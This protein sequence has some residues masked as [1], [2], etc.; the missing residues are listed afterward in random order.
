MPYYEFENIEQPGVYTDL[1]YHHYDAPKI[2]ETVIIERIIWK[3]IASKLTASIDTKFDPN[4]KKDFIKVT[5]KQGTFGEMFDRS[6]E[7]SELRKAQNGVDE[8]KQAYDAKSQ[9][10]GAES[11]AERK[12][13]AQALAKKRGVR[14]KEKR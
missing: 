1:F 11:P 12:A 5:N 13:K 10:P 6:K 8:V 14:I 7:F 4:S 3:R 9:M 2:G